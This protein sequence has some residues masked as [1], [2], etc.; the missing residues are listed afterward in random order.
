MTDLNSWTMWMIRYDYIITPA[1][2][3]VLA[4]GALILLALAFASISTR[5]P[6]R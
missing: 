3:I 4:L 1:M 6:G 5:T 2:F